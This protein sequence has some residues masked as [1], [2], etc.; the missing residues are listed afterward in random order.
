MLEFV[1]EKCQEHKHI[2]LLA[3]TAKLGVVSREN[4]AWMAETTDPQLYKCGVRKVAF[5]VPEN[6]FTKVSLELY[7]GKV[8]TEEG[9]LTPAQFTDR[10]EA[11]NWLKSNV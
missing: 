5:I 2:G 3:D 10:E 6:T 8:K 4:V 7:T 11:K 1:Q 9:K